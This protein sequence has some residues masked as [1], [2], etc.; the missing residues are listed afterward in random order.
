[1]N[2]FFISLHKNPPAHFTY[3][4]QPDKNELL[5]SCVALFTKDLQTGL[6]TVSP[7]INRVICVILIEGDIFET[8][9]IRE[10]IWKITVP[11]NMLKNIYHISLCFL[12]LLDK[13]KVTSDE[14]LRLKVEM[15]Q[16]K[17]N[18]TIMYQSNSDHIDNLVKKVDA[19]NTEITRR[20]Y[21]EGKLKESERQI[22]TLIGNLPGMV[23]RCLND[24]DWTFQFASEGCLELTGFPPEELTLNREINY[25]G[26]IHP[27]DR[28]WVWETVQK[29]INQQKPF[30]LGYRIITAKNKIKRVWEQG[31]GIFDLANK[32]LF[33][34]GFITELTSSKHAELALMESETKMRTIFES[35]RDALAVSFEGVLIMVNPAFIKMFGYTYEEE[36]LG[37]LVIKCLDSSVHEEIKRLINVLKRGEKI[38]GRYELLGKRKDGSIL[39]LDIKIS[40]FMLKGKNYNFAVI[41]DITAEKKAKA[42]LEG[43]RNY[44]NNIINS[45]PS[46]IIGVDES[47]R[48]T[49]WN[50]KASELFKRSNGEAIGQNLF[51]V[52]PHNGKGQL[53]IKKTLAS[54]K[55]SS[56]SYTSELEEGEVRHESISIFPVIGEQTKGAVIRIDDITDQLKMEEILSQSEKMLS[57]G[58]LAAG[59]A[60]EINNPL[61]GMM[62][63]AHV[64]SQRLIQGNGIPANISA[65]QEAG[66]QLEALQSFMVKRDIPTMLSTIIESGNRVSTIIKNML[67]FSR[68]TNVQKLPYNFNDLVEKTLQLASTDLD[69]KRRNEFGKITI[70]TKFEPHLPQI[71]CFGSKI[72]QVILNIIR[73]A[74]Q[75]HNNAQ[76]V[77]PI[78][79]LKTSYDKNNK[80]IILEIE[81]N[82][83]GMGKKTQKRVFEPFY[84]TKPIGQGTGLGLSVSYFIIKEIH[85]GAIEVESKL[86]KGTRFIIRLPQN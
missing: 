13:N 62:Q 80:H 3:K 85:N 33:I 71:E 20:K 68:T 60:H 78:I 1:M 81:D 7:Y 2:Y 56:T 58:S 73:N 63:T 82:G 57:I 70:H 17:K 46:V 86:D 40:Q 25:N 9:H 14:N 4:K 67:H 43:L 32:L 65:A 48:I 76:T 77:D 18:Q 49:H 47:S 29:S 34:E 53:Q 42:E 69:I 50:K 24:R 31:Q 8:T 10:H 83:P 26:I 45:M 72:Q 28:E 64:I 84:T 16:L 51:S 39:D 23:Y 19:L 12:Q 22:S 5:S 21:T 15:E 35:S 74:F 27:E 75:A 30:K 54:G 6:D 55:I 59:M 52:L 79:N 37:N 66:L 36:L 38:P 61:A 41:R 11:K 44:L